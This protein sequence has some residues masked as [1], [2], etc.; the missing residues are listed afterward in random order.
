MRSAA[1]RTAIG[2]R[3]RATRKKRIPETNLIWRSDRTL[4]VDV[5]VSIDLILRPMC[6]CATNPLVAPLEQS[7]Y[8]VYACRRYDCATGPIRVQFQLQSAGWAANIV[9]RRHW[10][11]SL[12]RSCRSGHSAVAR[13]GV[14]GCVHSYQAIE[15]EL[16]F[17]AAGKFY[18][19]VTI[20]RQRFVVMP[21]LVPP[22]QL[23]AFKEKYKTFYPFCCFCCCCSS[24]PLHLV[25][26]I[27]VSGYTP[28]QTINVEIDVDNQSETDADI[29]V[30]LIKVT[31]AYHVSFVRIRRA[32]PFS[33]ANFSFVCPLS[34]SRSLIIFMPIAP[35]SAQRRLW[36]ARNSR[37]V[38]RD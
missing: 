6:V 2:L 11:H 23:P 37:S 25:A 38:H 30:Q 7:P 24:D 14:R 35:S 26:R 18:D 12:S 21:F 33:S 34:F 3:D 5:M 17:N 9:G 22:L 32:P 15:F 16:R 27:P 1:A 8:V 29:S 10:L 4:L 31:V 20:V 36:S 28:G 13:C 19:L